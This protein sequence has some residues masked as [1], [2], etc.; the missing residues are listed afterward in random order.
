MKQAVIEIISF[1]VQKLLHDDDMKLNEE[2]LVNELINMGYS[3][4]EIDRAF[5]LIYSTT[6]II[7]ADK[8]E[9]TVVE[10]SPTYNRL[11]TWPERVYL[12]VKLQGIIRRLLLLNILPPEQYE[13]L[14]IK[15]IQGSY[16]GFNEIKDLWDILK[17]F[18][19]DASKLEAITAEIPEFQIYYNDRHKYIN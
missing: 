1:L 6:D 9:K 12:P 8:I 13:E 2:H 15:T 14:I 17:E 16:N 18:V 3:I 4:E 5:E 19:E 7:D 11:L 10:S